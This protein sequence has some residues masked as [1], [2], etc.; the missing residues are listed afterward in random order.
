MSGFQC[1]SLSSCSL[2]QGCSPPI[3]LKCSSRPTMDPGGGRISPAVGGSALCDPSGF[4]TTGKPFWKSACCATAKQSCK[5]ANFWGL[6][7]LFGVFCRASAGPQRWSCEVLCV[8][9]LAEV[10]ADFSSSDYFN[11]NIHGLPARGQV[12]ML[13]YSIIFYT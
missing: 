3:D 8:G 9:P 6:F 4:V 11:N 13:N 12:D 1:W 2:Q 10:G 5:R 7:F